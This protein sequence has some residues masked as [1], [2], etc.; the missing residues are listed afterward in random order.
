MA[1]A[2]EY[3]LISVPGNVVPSQ[4]TWDQLNK[5][6]KKKKLSQNWI[7]NV[8]NLKVGTLD[9]L[10]AVSDELTSIDSYIEQV[11]RKVACYTK[12]IIQ[13][14][15]EL[16]QILLIHGQDLNTSLINF[17]WD[18]AK[19][20]INQSLQSVKDMI[21]KQVTDI[22]AELKKR[23]QAYN[24]LKFEL[25]SKDKRKAGTLLT[26]DLSEFIRKEHVVLGSEY[27]TTLPVIVPN[28]LVNKWFWSYELLT[29]M[30][31]PRSTEI[32]YQD[33]DY[34][35]FMVT[36]F[37]KVV[38]EFKYKAKDKKF[39][40]RDFEF[41]PEEIER[42]L[43]EE[44]KLASEIHK[45]HGPLVRWLKV[46]FTESFEAWIHIKTLRVFS[47]SV[48]RY[49]LPVCFQAMLLLPELKSEK[50]LRDILRKM[51][52]NLDS[53]AS[54]PEDKSDIPSGLGMNLSEYFPYVS[55]RIN[56]DLQ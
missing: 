9:K 14:P 46:N 27:L 18:V 54:V 5:I 6:T 21:T 37:H 56:V 52:G 49:G 23:S 2:S 8:P 17:K 30:V 55:L 10:V 24:K 11:M 16:N 36:V 41:N 22:E 25:Q 35:L 19:Y 15:A 33:N 3:L 39:I 4:Q 34:S 31:V 40:V 13:D 43:E 44:S 28:N 12:E 26:R 29:D 50:K 47:E 45:K 51:Y 20:P 7:F 32:V 48:L 42:N 1:K 38:D 53:L